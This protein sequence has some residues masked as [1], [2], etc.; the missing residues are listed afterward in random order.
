ME[1]AENTDAETSPPSIPQER[2]RFW[3]FLSPDNRSAYLR[4]PPKRSVLAGK[5][6][7][8]KNNGHLKS[9]VVRGE[10]P[11]ATRGL[12][13]GILCLDSGITI[14]THQLRLILSTCKCSI[15]L[16]DTETHSVTKFQFSFPTSREP[17]HFSSLP[18]DQS[19][20]ATL[21]GSV[22]FKRRHP[23]M[24]HFSSP[25]MRQSNTDVV[26][27]ERPPEAPRDLNARQHGSGGVPRSPCPTSRSQHRSGPSY[28]RLWFLCVRNERSTKHCAP[29][30]VGAEFHGVARAWGVEDIQSAERVH[31]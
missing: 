30:N 23:A 18:P 28:Q 4:L 13:C 11:D 22:C 21:N 17:L 5:S 19:T 14:N 16:F 27:M 20:S 10:S 3:E 25:Q 24:E 29:V 12:I 1:M 15:F 26:V 9:F 7:R 31:R 2:P 6:R 8:S